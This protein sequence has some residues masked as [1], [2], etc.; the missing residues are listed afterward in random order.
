LIEDNG[1]G[2]DMELVKPGNGLQNMKQRASL[3]KGA[4]SINSQP[5]AGTR[6]MLEMP[7]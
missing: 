3:L 5:G 7:V 2:F 1:T 4:L 6:L